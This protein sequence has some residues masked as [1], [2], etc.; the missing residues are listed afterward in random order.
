MVWLVLYTICPW[1]S[2]SVVAMKRQ[3]Q[4]THFSHHKSHTVRLFSNTGEGKKGKPRHGGTDE[5]EAGLPGQ[6]TDCHLPHSPTR[7]A[8]VMWLDSHIHPSFP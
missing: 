5:E 8:S 3:T 2:E 4:Q 6:G 1:K 7:L